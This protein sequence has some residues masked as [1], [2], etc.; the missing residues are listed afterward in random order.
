MDIY[1]QVDKNYR[2][3]KSNTGKHTVSDGNVLLGELLAHLQK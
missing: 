3:L 2:R 1:K